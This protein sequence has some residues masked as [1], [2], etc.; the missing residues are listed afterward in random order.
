MIA[1]STTIATATATVHTTNTMDD[2]NTQVFSGPSTGVGISLASNYC[3][4]C[5]IR[6]SGF[7]ERRIHAK[8]EQQ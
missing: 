5:D 1:V 6:L 2:N 3:S 4:I 8:G 7:E